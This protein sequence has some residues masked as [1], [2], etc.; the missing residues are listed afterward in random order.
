ETISPNSNNLNYD[1][2]VVAGYLAYTYSAKSGYSIKAGSRYE[3]TSINAY[4]ETESDI[5]IPAYGAFV[6]SINVSKKFSNGKTLKAAFNRRIQRPSI[7]YLNPNKQGV[8]Q[9]V[10]YTKGNPQLDPEF[11]N[12]YELSYSTFIKGTTLSFTG[13]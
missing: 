10:E 4:T 8:N 5:D 11:S 12:N 6:P 13:F 2:N 7:R 1:Q 9:E 3:Y